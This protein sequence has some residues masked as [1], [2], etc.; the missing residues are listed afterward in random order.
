VY[1]LARVI[2]TLTEQARPAERPLW[3]PWT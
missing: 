1:T 2:T 3:W